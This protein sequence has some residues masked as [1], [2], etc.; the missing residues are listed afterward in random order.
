MSMP[1]LAKKKKEKK[2]VLISKR[3]PKSHGILSAPCA[4]WLKIIFPLYDLCPII[5]GS[6][7]WR[8]TKQTNNY[9]N[10]KID[11]SCLILSFCVFW[12]L[13]RRFFAFMNERR[14]V[15]GLLDSV[16]NERRFVCW[17]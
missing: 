12:L 7:G 5:S 6:L 3:D 16:R 10:I 9:I 2:V 4:L 1:A 13:G 17:F 15:C 11:K 8:M 14:F